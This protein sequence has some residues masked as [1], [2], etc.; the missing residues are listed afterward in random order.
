MAA[1]QQFAKQ[2]RNS[3]VEICVQDEGIG[4]TSNQISH[5]FRPFVQV[6]GIPEESEGSGLGLY[7]SQAIVQ[8]HGGRLQLESPGPGKG[9]RATFT[10]STNRGSGIA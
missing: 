7:L 2:V 8:A 1:L 10:L 3:H 6:Q 5:V 9:T 4:L